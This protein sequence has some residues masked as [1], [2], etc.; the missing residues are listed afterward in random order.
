MTPPVTNPK[1]IADHML[2]SLA[3]WL[4]MLG[5]DTIYDKRLDD[6]Q[7]AIVAREQGRFILTRDRELAKEPG[8]FFVEP[9][10]LDEQLKAAGQKFGLKFNDANIRCSACNGDLV[11]LPKEQAKPDV[12]EGAFSANDKFWRC[13][14][15]GK[16]YWM[17][18]HWRGIMDRLKK[19]NLA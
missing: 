12:P 18:T 1:F 11:D 16:V 4:R 19:L 5:Y 6:A 7:M 2:G 17:G 15:C 3:R 14:K 13:A 10:D 9:D 8:A